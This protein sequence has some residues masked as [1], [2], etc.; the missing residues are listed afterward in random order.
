MTYSRRKV[1][2]ARTANDQKVTESVTLRFD[3]CTLERLRKEANDKQISLNTLMNQIIIQ[4]LDWH[5]HASKAGFIAIRKGT[6]LKMLEKIPEQDVVGIAE[7]VAK[8]ESKGSIMM[9][10]NEYSVISALEVLE[11]WIKIAGY[12]YRHEAED[13]EHSFVIYHD[14]GKKWSLYL[15]ELF[16]FISEDFGLS[17]AQFDID[18]NAISFRVHTDGSR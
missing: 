9:L 1:A 13:S 10:R 17:R 2:A 11:T 8:K 12:S 18:E 5:A 6:I 14:M 4:H 3:T 7:F 15:R 16:R